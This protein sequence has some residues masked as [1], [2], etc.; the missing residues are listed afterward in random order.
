MKNIVLAMVLCLLACKGL[1]AQQAYPVTD[2]QPT[3][4][5]GLQFGYTIKSTETKK[6]GDKGDFS[7]YSVRFY[8]T[9]PTNESKIIL[10]KQGWNVM[11][12]VSDQLGQFNCLN[13][14]GARLTSKEAIISAPACNVLAI[15]S[16]KDGKPD[17]TKRFAQIGYWIKA[18]QTIT[19]DC[20]LITPL[21]ELPNVQ[22]IYLANQLQ[23]AANAS[24]GL[25]NDQQPV[26][27]YPRTLP[28]QGL[29]S[30][31]LYIRNV[32]LNTFINNQ[33]G[34]LNST[35]IDNN[36]WSAQWTLVPV[37]RTNYYN[38]Q[39][40][41]KDSY[42]TTDNGGIN[43]VG[44]FG[45]YMSD[46]AR[47]ELQ[48][49]PDGGYRLRNLATGWFLCYISDMLKLA[50]NYNNVQTAEWVFEQH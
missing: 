24:A 21:N 8:V 37:P 14:T 41:W 32:Q 19:A 42:L 6:V 46:G 33:T 7:R 47:W 44:L 26:Q 17:N 35:T 27:A 50:K 9:N 36:W 30:G 45:N 28:A 15:V 16:D 3:V 20:I 2:Q 5:D 25:Q 48:P 39:N 23:P 22:V 29:P 49:C 1:R 31:F 43:G 18:G 11:G 34:Q 10:Y 13:A 38:I 40:R 12:N 4:I